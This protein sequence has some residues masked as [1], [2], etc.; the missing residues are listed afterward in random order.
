MVQ[1]FQFFTVFHSL[2]CSL[3]RDIDDDDDDNDDDDGGDSDNRNNLYS[4]SQ[5]LTC[6]GTIFTQLSNQCVR[7]M[8]LIANFARKKWNCKQNCVRV[9]FAF[10][11]AHLLRIYE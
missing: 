9:C 10:G 1:A 2:L 3:S 6:P 8:R 7:E 4:S 11:F 5:H